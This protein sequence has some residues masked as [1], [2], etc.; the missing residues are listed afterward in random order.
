M[1]SITLEKPIFSKLEWTS[2]ETFSD[3]PSG[4]FVPSTNG[5]LAISFEVP[6]N[7]SSSALTKL[8][9]DFY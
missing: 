8:G 1:D 9:S 7:F 5:G 3:P 2:M 6:N 4:G